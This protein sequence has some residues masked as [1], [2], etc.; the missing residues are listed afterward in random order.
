VVGLG[1]L[2]LPTSRLSGGRSNRLSYRPTVRPPRSEQSDRSMHS[3]PEKRITCGDGEG[4]DRRPPRL[5]ESPGGPG[6]QDLPTSTVAGDVRIDFDL[7]CPGVPEPRLQS[8]GSS[9]ERR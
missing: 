8:P 5:N 9:L 2:E 7:G 4:A 6:I 1:R 3:V